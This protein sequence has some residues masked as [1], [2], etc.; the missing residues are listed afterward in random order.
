MTAIRTRPATP[1]DRGFMFD[2]A[3]RLTSVAA[4]PWHGAR[5]YQDDSRLTK[6]L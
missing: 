5:G 1:D 2:Q 6:P 3:P 4:L